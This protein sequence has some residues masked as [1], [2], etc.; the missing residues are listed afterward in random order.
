MLE[1]PGNSHNTASA[2]WNNFTN[3]LESKCKRGGTHFVEVDPEDT[4]KK[5]A[6]C[7]VKT[8]KPLW[9]REHSCPACGFEAGRGAN[10]AWNILFTGF[11]N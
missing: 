6:S 8:D 3:L 9:V 2:A 11:Q 1:S 10:A 7:G 4:I 5:C